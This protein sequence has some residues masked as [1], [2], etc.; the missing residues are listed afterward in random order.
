MAFTCY[1]LSAIH[2]L[3]SLKVLWAMCRHGNVYKGPE[4][5]PSEVAIVGNCSRFLPVTEQ[6]QEASGLC[7]FKIGHHDDAVLAAPNKRNP[8]VSSIIHQSVTLSPS[9]ACKLT[10]GL[11]W[12][13]FHLAEA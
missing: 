13:H 11:G 1:L 9:K 6:S 8:H 10:V 2:T 4:A 7:P 12:P 5:S 3:L